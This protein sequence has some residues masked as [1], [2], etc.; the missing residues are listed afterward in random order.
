MSLFAGFE[1]GKKGLTASQ[2]GQSTT[3]HNIGKADE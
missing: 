1:I 2:L 3:G